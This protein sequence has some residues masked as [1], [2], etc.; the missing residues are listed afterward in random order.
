MVSTTDQVLSTLRKDG[1]QHDKAKVYGLIEEVV[2]P[3]FDFR[4]MS[5]WVLGKH[6][7][8]ANPEEQGRFEEEFRKLL[9][10]TY[11]TALMEYTNEEVAYLPFHGEGAA[12]IVTVKTQINRQG[13]PAIPIDYSLYK[14]DSDWKVFD[15]SIDGISLVTTYRSELSEQINNKG[16]NGLIQDLV[17][18]NQR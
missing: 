1:I 14:K 5:Q 7:R 10:R 16:I 17:A 8:A 6:W 4:K 11:S 3:H 9:V 15:V 18:K 2:L 12:E 13:G